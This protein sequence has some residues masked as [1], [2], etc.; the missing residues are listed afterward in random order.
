MTSEYHSWFIITKPGTRVAC[1]VSTLIDDV[2]PQLA[3]FDKRQMTRLVKGQVDKITVTYD[4]NEWVIE[5][6]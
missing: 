2:Y 1:S 4:N 3:Q 6:F 5:A